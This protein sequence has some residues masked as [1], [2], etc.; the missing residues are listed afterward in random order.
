MGLVSLLLYPGVD[1][2]LHS[3]QIA[4]FLLHKPQ[5]RHDVGVSDACRGAEQIV[6]RWAVA[7]HLVKHVA[8]SY[9]NKRKAGEKKTH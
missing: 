4:G 3:E 6:H 9:I 2:S 1:E 5:V 7:I 8:H